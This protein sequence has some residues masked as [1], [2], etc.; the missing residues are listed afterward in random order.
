MR[1][2]GSLVTL[3]AMTSFALTSTALPDGSVVGPQQ[4][5]PALGGENL[6]PDLSWSG[7]PEGTASFAVTC[8]DPDAPTGSG[9]WHW[10]A[11]DI[12]ASQTSLPLGVGRDAGFPQ[13]RN[14]FGS[15]GYDGPE[16]PAGPPHRYIF[17]VHALPVASLGADPEAPHIGARFA[18][19]TQRIGSAALTGT[20]QVTS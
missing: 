16:P 12:P 6:S 20:Y 4:L 9:F 3:G 7:A 14:D 11:W 18:I 19:H 8:F 2:V 17:T 15:V 10:I 13:A 5:V 1:S